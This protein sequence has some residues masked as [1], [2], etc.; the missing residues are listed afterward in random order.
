MVDERS[1][2]ARVLLFLPMIDPANRKEANCIVRE[3][4]IPLQ[5]GTLEND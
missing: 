1:A 5:F 2:P 3:R 4:Q